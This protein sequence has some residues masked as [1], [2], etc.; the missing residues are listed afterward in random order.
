VVDP[1]VK[2]LITLS[3]EK[4]VTPSAAWNQFLAALRLQGF[5]VIEASGLYKIVPEAEAN[6]KAVFQPLYRLPTHPIA[7]R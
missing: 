1:R 6:Y 3:A 7:V 5:S 2:G 4:P